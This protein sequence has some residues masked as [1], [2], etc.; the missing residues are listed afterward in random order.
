MTQRSSQTAASGNRNQRSGTR[1]HS[2]ARAC[3]TLGTWLALGLVS[4]LGS[5]LVSCAPAAFGGVQVLPSTSSKPANSS[6]TGPLVLTSAPSSSL[7]EYAQEF[8]VPLETAGVKLELA[9]ANAFSYM[10]EDEKAFFQAVDLFYTSHPGFCPVEGGFLTGAKRN[11]VT[12]AADVAGVQVWAFAY[13]LSAKP[14]FRGAFIPGKSTKVLKVK[15]C[16]TKSGS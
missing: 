11:F 2:Q 4:G 9:A 15:P 12:L 8:M 6:P 14:K 16:Q 13:D 1:S 7:G 10:G 5:G 3:S